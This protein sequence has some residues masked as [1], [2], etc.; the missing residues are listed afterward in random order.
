MDYQ[1]V[2]LQLTRTWSIAR[3]A[4]TDVIRVIVVQ[5][6]DVDGLVGLLRRD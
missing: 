1:R 2:D 3:T 6:T 4:A 5:L